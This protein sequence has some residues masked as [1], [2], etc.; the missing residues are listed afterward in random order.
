M[1]PRSLNDSIVI[2]LTCILNLKIHVVM[3]K[4]VIMLKV[5]LIVQLL[6]V[7]LVGYPFFFSKPKV[8]MRV[9]YENDE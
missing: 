1:D 5:I 3:S 9:G 4:L 6:G 7:S 2:T 8:V